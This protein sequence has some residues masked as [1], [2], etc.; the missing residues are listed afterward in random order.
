V[1]ITFVNPWIINPKPNPQARF[2]LFCFPYAGGGASVFRAWP[3][4]LPPEL[5]VCAIQLPGRENRLQERP[6]SQF[7]KVVCTLAEVLL[8]YLKGPFAF[9]GHSMG[10][11]IS[12]EL[13]R[14]LR[15]EHKLSPFHL[16]VSGQRAPQKPDPYPPLHQLPDQE[17]I[18]GLHN[19]YNSIPQA[20]LKSAELMQILLPIL[21]AD[22]TVNETYA[23]Q[24]DNPLD[25]PITAFG[26]Q[27]DPETRHDDLLAWRDQTSDAFTLRMLPGG[28]F[29]LENARTLLLQALNDDL[30]NSINGSV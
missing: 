11:F 19:R 21:R 13:A 30:K 15:K 12:F 22:L 14:H 3:D 23:Y 17:F 18:E 20:V 27:E 25:C 6:L 4:Y 10:A 5:E 26:G 9:F 8:P 1:Q 24:Y 16:F 29:F 7:P 28:H 2:R